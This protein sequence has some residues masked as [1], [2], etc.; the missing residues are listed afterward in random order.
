MVIEHSDNEIN[1]D[2]IKSKQYDMRDEH[3]AL[4]NHNGELALIQGNPITMAA[5]AK[6]FSEWRKKLKKHSSCSS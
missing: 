2:F 1:T 3:S 6:S 4:E 5:A